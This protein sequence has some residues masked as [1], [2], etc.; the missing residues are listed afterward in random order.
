MTLLYQVMIH[1]SFCYY[2]IVVIMY[3]AL[4]VC[5]NKIDYPKIKTLRT[6][7]ISITN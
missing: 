1:P 3:F 5:K 2:G 7:E 6:V 4:F